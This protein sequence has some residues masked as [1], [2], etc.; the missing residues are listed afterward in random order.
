MIILLD[1]KRALHEA[2]QA[3]L[4][5]LS[6]IILYFNYQ[7]CIVN[8]T[9]LPWKTKLYT[10]WAI[11]QIFQIFLTIIMIHI[12]KI[13]NTIVLAVVSFYIILPV[14]DSSP[15]FTNEV[16]VLQWLA[17]HLEKDLPIIHSCYKWQDALLFP[18]SIKVYCIDIWH[19]WSLFIWWWTLTVSNLTGNMNV[20]CTTSKY[21]WLNIMQGNYWLTPV[22]SDARSADQ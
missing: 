11:I 22:W 3:F 13:W 5:I 9:N 7:H 10:H 21:W 20:W 12:P 4:N 14:L 18:K 6:Y 8:K 16:I 2:Q 17:C 1:R 15:S 19:F